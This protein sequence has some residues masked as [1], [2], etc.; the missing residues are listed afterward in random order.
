MFINIIHM[1]DKSNTITQNVRYIQQDE[2]SL[3]G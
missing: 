1:L 2:L 3:F